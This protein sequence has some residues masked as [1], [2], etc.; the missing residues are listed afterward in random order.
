MALGGR[1]DL[2]GGSVSLGLSFGVSNVQA[3]PS[4]SLFLL[5]TDP[6]VELAAPLQ[7]HVSLNAT[8]LPTLV[9]VLLL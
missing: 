3:R 7:H 4:G 2:V 6:D 9:R 1:Y 5:L 8:M